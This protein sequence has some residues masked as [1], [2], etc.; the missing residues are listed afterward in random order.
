MSIKWVFQILWYHGLHVRSPTIIHSAAPSPLTTRRVTAGISPALHCYITL[1]Y[2]DGLSSDDYII[3]KVRVSFPEPR[4]TRNGSLT[5][6]PPL[7][8]LIYSLFAPLYSL[9]LFA[10]FVI[11]LMYRE[12]KRKGI[13]FFS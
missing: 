2:S 6:V 11:V 9:I 3:N 7:D 8:S 13:R 5:G 12:K 4:L 10:C 1:L